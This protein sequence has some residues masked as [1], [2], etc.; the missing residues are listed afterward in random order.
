MTIKLT[1]SSLLSLPSIPLLLKLWL[2]MIFKDKAP[3]PSLPY[4]KT[5]KRS[6]ASVL[7]TPEKQAVISQAT[8]TAN[9]IVITSLLILRLYL[10]HQ[11]EAPILVN[12]AF[13]DTVFK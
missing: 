7:K 3:R 9:K 5:I 13:V 8:V 6:L 10:M 1:V 12:V 11:T 2:P 4:Y